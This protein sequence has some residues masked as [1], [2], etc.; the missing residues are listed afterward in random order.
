[1][2]PPT[3]PKWSVELFA[4][5]YTIAVDLNHKE[6]IDQLLRLMAELY[7]AVAEVSI[8]QALQMIKARD[9]L[10]ARTLLEKTETAH[11]RNAQVKALMA[12]TLYMQRERSWEAYAEEALA[13]PPDRTA[14][15]LVEMMA[16]ITNMPI[17]G[18]RDAVAEPS[19]DPDMPFTGLAC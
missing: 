4:D 3:L 18:P 6:G 19:R 10:N 12:W 11:P 17:Q 5:V 14:T 9:F 16:R 1:M 15:V 13:L 2:P 7:P 8:A